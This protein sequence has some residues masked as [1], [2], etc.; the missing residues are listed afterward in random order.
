MADIQQVR[1]AWHGRRPKPHS[2]RQH[3]NDYNSKSHVARPIPRQAEVN[4]ALTYSSLT[5]RPTRSRCSPRQRISTGQKV[6]GRGLRTPSTPAIGRQHRTRSRH[7]A[8]MA[9]RPWT[10]PKSAPAMA[11]LVSVSPPQRTV[12]MTPAAKSGAWRSWKKAF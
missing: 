6:R 12:S 4:R 5:C 7:W 9:S 1:L 2:S 11:P 3:Y 8:G 10:A